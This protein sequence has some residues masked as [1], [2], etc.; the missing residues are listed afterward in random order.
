MVINTIHRRKVE[1][2]AGQDRPGRSKRRRQSAG[3]A[4]VLP[5][6]DG[7]LGLAADLDIV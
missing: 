4:V 6:V 2:R 3:R 5:E 7:H 1:K